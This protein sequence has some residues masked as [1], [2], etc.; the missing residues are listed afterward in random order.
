MLYK[1]LCN[2]NRSKFIPSVITLSNLQGYNSAITDLNIP[3]Y[4]I[5]LSKNPLSFLKIIKLFHLLYKISPSIVHTWMYHSD[6]LGGLIAHIIG[7]P[8]IIWCVRHSN[9]SKNTVK[10]STYLIMRLCSL[11]SNKIPHKIIYCS[12]KSAYIH[13]NFG[14]NKPNTVIISNGFDLNDF[15]PSTENR[16]NL[17]NE[18]GTS[19]NSFLVGQVGRFHPQKNH[20]GFLKAACQL[21]S[22]FS[23]IHFLL[24]GEGVS[25]ENQLLSDY[26][27]ENNLCSV[28]H[29]MGLRHDVSY[30]MSALDILVSPSTHGEAFPN[31]LGE[32]MS[33]GVPCVVTDVGDSAEIVGNT[34]F[35]VKCSDTSDLVTKISKLINLSKSQRSQLSINARI[36]VQLEYNILNIVKLYESV[37]LSYSNSNIYLL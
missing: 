30:V 7:V 36:R 22:N 26:I 9:F 19:P 2:I 1:L 4:S 18:L 15:R 10:I 17:R 24:V 6:L 20:L 14:Y 27:K 34:G 23:Q 13:Q 31:V 8:K 35:V 11:I 5:G 21:S 12:K 32:A 29:L 16:L 3:I 37:Y 28:V 25:S 33:C